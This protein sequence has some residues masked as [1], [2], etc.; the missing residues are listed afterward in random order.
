MS[1]LDTASITVFVCTGLFM[2]GSV[3][4]LSKI[5]NRV[6][7][8]SAVT[9]A[10][11]DSD[12]QEETTETPQAQW[13]TDLERLRSECAASD[14]QTRQTLDQLSSQI[15]KLGEFIDHSLKNA[16]ATPAS[17]KTVDTTQD[18]TDRLR[19]KL[20]SVMAQNIRLK[21]EMESA[22]KQ[23]LLASEGG[24]GLGESIGNS[25]A[26][27]QVIKDLNQQCDA[28]R[29]DLDEARRRTR[30]AEKTA[31]ENAFRIEELRDALSVQQRDQTIAETRAVQKLRAELEEKQARER[32][33]LVRIE[34]MES[35]FARHLTEKNFIEERYMRLDAV[36]QS[37]HSSPSVTVN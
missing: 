2:L 4:L 5:L 28:L 22:S 9:Q 34:T 30:V 3:I 8:N 31:E 33:L 18:L 27:P 35:E 24:R 17:P 23:I 29:A 19:D 11:A 36:P 26:S 15:V 21:A 16:A 13:S 32:A 10:E 14:R 12:P 1:W 7:A 20:K 37:V 25:G 6:E